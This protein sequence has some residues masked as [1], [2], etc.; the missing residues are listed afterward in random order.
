MNH[1]RVGVEHVEAHVRG[2]QGDRRA[3]ES[4]AARRLPGSGRHYRAGKEWCV[5]LVVGIK[6][7]VAAMPLTHRAD[8][9]FADAVWN[10]DI[11]AVRRLIAKGADSNTA[12]KEMAPH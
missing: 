9:A 1:K 10:G 6:P 12:T 3:G 7:F 2:D 5:S 8:K 4:G 11:D